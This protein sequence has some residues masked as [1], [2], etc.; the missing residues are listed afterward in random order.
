MPFGHLLFVDWEHKLLTLTIL[1]AGVYLNFQT[2]VLR[3]VCVQYYADIVVDPLI[4][5][6][7]PIVST[8]KA[9]LSNDPKFDTAVVQKG[10]SISYPNFWTSGQPFYLYMKNL[11][12]FHP[13]IQGFVKTVIEKED[14][15]SEA[16]GIPQG[17][18]TTPH[19]F[20]RYMMAWFLTEET[21]VL[22]VNDQVLQG[23]NQVLNTHLSLLSALNL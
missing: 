21:K 22:A 15:D 19:F 6:K 7:F 3:N 12:D 11:G 8:T 17:T 1:L 4:K 23:K 2:S 16:T 18:F 14:L 13:H 20:N 10:G 9:L 5:C